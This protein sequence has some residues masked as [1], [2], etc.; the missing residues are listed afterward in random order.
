MKMKKLMIML[1]GL[2]IMTVSYGQ[3]IPK[4][5]YSEVTITSTDGK[6]L[7]KGT[8]WDGKK[9]GYWYSY[10]TNGKLKASAQ[11]Y[12]GK[13]SGKWKFYNLEGVLIGEVKYKDNMRISAVS[14]IDFNNG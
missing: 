9:D 14:Y 6:L 8:Y 13:R 11:F 10:H 1:L 3:N 5:G 2:M 4:N 12:K 7:E